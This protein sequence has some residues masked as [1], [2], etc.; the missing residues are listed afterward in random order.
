MTTKKE[1]LGIIETWGVPALIA[2]ADA[3]AKTADVEVTAYEKVDAGIVTIY[4]LGDV[5]AVKTAVDAGGEAAKRVGKLLGT[6]VIPRPDSSVFDMVQGLFPKERD[7]R[8]PQ[9]EGNGEG[10]GESS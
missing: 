5:A 8:D 9:A 2:A 3:A 1:A 6:H 4:V 10:K 7:N